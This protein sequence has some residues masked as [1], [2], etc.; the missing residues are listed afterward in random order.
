VRG[1]SSQCGV[2]D[3]RDLYRNPGSWRSAEPYRVAYLAAAPRS[4]NQALLAWFQ[5]GMR[6]LGYVEGRN[7]V[8][9][10]RR[11]MGRSSRRRGR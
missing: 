1:T 3:P 7:L 10:L 8:F 11:F 5:Q 4:G 2:K 6:E 9:E